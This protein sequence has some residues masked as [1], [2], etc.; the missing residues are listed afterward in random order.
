MVFNFPSFKHYAVGLAAVL[1]LFG[2][3]YLLDNGFDLVTWSPLTTLVTGLV[4][5][6]C[7]GYLFSAQPEFGNS[8]KGKSD[9][10][11]HTK[12]IYVGNLPFRTTRYEL[13]ELFQPYGKVHTVRIMINK[14]TRKPRGYGFVEMPQD[15]A[16]RAISQ[17]DGTSFI[18]R[19]LKISE[20][21]ERG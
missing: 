17:L 6:Q 21:N 10:N 15:D 4:V 19:N 20:A 12:T 11:N 2:G 8:Q 1:I 5:G 18:G 7:A 14:A 9:R 13:K 16:A 3:F